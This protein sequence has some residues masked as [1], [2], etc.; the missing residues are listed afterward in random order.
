MSTNEAPPSYEEATEQEVGNTEQDSD[1]PMTFTEQY[2][3]MLIIQIQSV[4]TDKNASIEDKNAQIANIEKLIKLKKKNSSSLFDTI[5][6]DQLLNLKKKMEQKYEIKT[7]VSFSEHVTAVRAAYPN[8]TYIE[9][10]KKATK[11]YAPIKEEKH[12]YKFYRL[13][14]L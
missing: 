8:L 11:T 14:R 7:Y 9:A 5:E 3:A 10:R 1:Q 4:L 12:I 6:L 2:M 13:F